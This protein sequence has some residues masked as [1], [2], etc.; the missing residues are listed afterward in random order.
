MARACPNCQSPDL[1][2]I[3]Q[4]PC[5]WRHEGLDCIEKLKQEG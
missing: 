2:T 1:A 3:E 5:G 4:L